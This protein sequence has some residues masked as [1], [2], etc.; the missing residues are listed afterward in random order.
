[1][2]LYY[3]AV[4][5]TFGCAL[6]SRMADEKRYKALAMFWI[7]M[8]MAILVFFSGTRTG[9]GDT[10]MYK[11]TYTR[12]VANPTLGNSSGDYGFTLLNI[13][14]TKFSSDPQTIV[15]V[16]ALITNIANIYV[17]RKYKSAMELQVFM[18]IAAGYFTVT[19]N[20]MRQ[21]L[22][23]SLL[24]LCTPLI[25]KGKFKKFLIY[26]VLISTIHQSA[27]IMIPVYFIVKMKPWT[28]KF[29]I[30][31]A[32]SCIGLLLY[33]VI[34]P[35]IFK[36]LENTNYGYYS[37]FQEGGS[38]ILRT[39]VNMVPMGLAYIKRDE[40]KKKWPESDI[41][42]NMAL[43]NCIFVG[44]GMA[45]WIFNRFSLYFQLYNFILLPYIIKNCL[46]GKER[47]F[48]YCSFMGCYTF[49]FYWEQNISLALRY[50]SILF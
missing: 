36:V 24:F 20:G 23:A 35:Y 19:M 25:L 30:I 37:D 27:L 45:N 44:F 16:T 38:S 12:L 14:L 18:Y 49:F 6:L 9:I 40:L 22:A 2:E 11:H 47:R 50:S 39:I 28:K 29:Y 31:I 46:Y 26:V 1:M 32:L 48:V 13:I 41:F 15:F 4:A 10:G 43:I 33:N 3:G 21:C 34:T 5:M 7:L 42:V 17:F 8:V